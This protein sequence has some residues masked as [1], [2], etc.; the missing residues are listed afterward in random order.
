MRV[1]FGLYQQMSS[2]LVESNASEMGSEPSSDSSSYSSASEDELYLA[3]LSN[4][5]EAKVAELGTDVHPDLGPLVL[6]YADALLTMEENNLDPLSASN[7]DEESTDDLQL[8]WEC[9]EQARLCLA[10]SGPEQLSFIHQRL[11]D[12]SSL[13]GNFEVAVSE[14]LKAKELQTGGG[15][16]SAGVLVPLG[17]A[18]LMLQRP[19]EA[20]AAFLEAQ[21]ALADDPELQAE[22]Q[23]SVKECDEN[24]KEQHEA[25]LK[26]GGLMAAGAAVFDAPTLNQEKILVAP[27]RKKDRDGAGESSPTHKKPKSDGNT[28][29]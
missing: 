17:N 20:K 1:M 14:Y 13:Q 15:R 24:I 28:A 22:I 3:E 16:Q 9:F 6:K 5:I 12:L 2:D 7:P 11:G 10:E 25:K 21:A 27:V 4:A 23:E 8:A 19:E 18:L 29:E 26:I